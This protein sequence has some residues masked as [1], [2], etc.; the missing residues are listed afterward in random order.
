ML[1]L[2]AY[3]SMLINH[4]FNI[5]WIGVALPIFCY[6][7]VKGLKFTRNKEKYIS[8]ILITGM[9]SQLFWPFRE[10]TN[11]INDL[12]AIGVSL[13]AIE[14]NKKADILKVL[15][16]IAWIQGI[17]AIEPLYLM[18]ASKQKKNIFY[19]LVMI[20]SVTMCFN[21]IFQLRWLLSI[22]FIELY[23]KKVLTGVLKINKYAKYSIYPLHLIFLF[24]IR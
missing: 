2:I 15:L 12:L 16:L 5:E 7:S 14:E 9:I 8:R 19:L 13:L 21:Y 1:Q 20:F 10:N 11:Q 22:I 24:F 17:I 18:I 6:M 3:S 4:I 23:E